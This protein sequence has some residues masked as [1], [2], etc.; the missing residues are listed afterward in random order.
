VERFDFDAFAGALWSLWE[1]LDRT[2]ERIGI[3]LQALTPVL[4]RNATGRRDK[5][6]AA[7]WKNAHSKKMLGEWIWREAGQ[8]FDGNNE[9]EIMKLSR[10]IPARMR[11][12]L[13][14]IAKSIPAP[15]GGNPRALDMLNSWRA[16]RQVQ[17][18]REKGLSRG[19]AYKRVADQMRVSAHTV[20][21]E[22]EPSERERSK[23]PKDKDVAFASLEPR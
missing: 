3:P 2:A 22:C 15:R 11:R 20:R 19:K 17:A 10:E 12:N 18:L 8:D 7:L 23:Q 9:T 13:I 6:E 14:Q 1:A 5:W 21:R 4:Y 16:R